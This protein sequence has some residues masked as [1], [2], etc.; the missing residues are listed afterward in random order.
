MKYDVY[1]FNSTFPQ[2]IT[3]V[4]VYRSFFTVSTWHLSTDRLKSGYEIFVLNH[5][6]SLI[7]Y[8]DIYRFIIYEIGNGQTFDG[9]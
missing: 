6:F 7:T 3:Q 9:Y 5:I 2:F 4:P 1:S 8:K